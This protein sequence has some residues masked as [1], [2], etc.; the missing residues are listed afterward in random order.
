LYGW[1]SVISW[2]TCTEHDIAEAS[3]W[4]P[5]SLIPGDTWALLKFVSR[6]SLSVIHWRAGVRCFPCLF[7]PPASRYQYEKCT[8]GKC[9]EKWTFLPSTIPTYIGFCAFLTSRWQ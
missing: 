9:Q 8:W 7:Q 4:Q 5:L 1:R 6:S 3:S 2:E